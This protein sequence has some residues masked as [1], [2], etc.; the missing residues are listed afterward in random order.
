MVTAPTT[1]LVYIN[2]Y[3]QLL[4]LVTTNGYKQLLQLASQ[5]RSGS[6]LLYNWLLHLNNHKEGQENGSQYLA[7]LCLL[8]FS[9]KQLFTTG[10][11]KWLLFLLHNWL[12]QMVTTHYFNCVQL[13]T[14]LCSAHIWSGKWK[15]LFLRNLQKLE[16]TYRWLVTTLELAHTGFDRWKQF[17]GET[18]L[19]RAYC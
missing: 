11:Y 1:H 2:G 19:P 10:Y 16:L 14:A 13:V 7:Q 5:I 3:K 9:S 18:Y 8:E 6:L 15:P 12:I 4:Q 17:F